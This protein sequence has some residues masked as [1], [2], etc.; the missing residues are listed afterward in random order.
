MTEFVALPGTLTAAAESDAATPD[1]APVP[2]LLQ[3]PH[4]GPADATSASTQRATSR[5]LESSP[6]PGAAG[7]A[8]SERGALAGVLARWAG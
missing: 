2:G 7:K 8:Q 4:A 5:A 3:D 1:P 6:A